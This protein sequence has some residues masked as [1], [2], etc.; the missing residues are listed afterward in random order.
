MPRAL[1]GGW[2]AAG[3]LAVVAGVA[4]TGH[5]SEDRSATES[6]WSAP[7][8]VT[9][10]QDGLAETIVLADPSGAVHLFFADGQSTRRQTTDLRYARW[11]DGHWS[12]P[13]TLV[14]PRGAAAFIHPALALDE[15]GRLHAVYGGRRSGRIEYR[16][17]HLSEVTD[18]KAWTGGRT[19]SERGGLHSAVATAPGGMVYVL[20]SSHSH[21]VSFH[22]SD[23]GGRTWSAPVRLSE[24][25]PSQQACDDP[26]LAVDG[27][28]RLHVVWTQFHLPQGWPPAGVYYRRSDDA[29]LT[30]QAARLVAGEGH[31]RITVATHGLDE[32]HLAW[33]VTATGERMH[34]WSDDGGATWSGARPISTRIRGAVSRALALA[35]DSGGILHL[36]AGVGGPG[37]GGPIVHTWW[38]GA[39]WSEPQPVSQDP[40]Q[41]SVGLPSLAISQ[42][43][44]LHVIYEDPDQRIW[45]ID[46][47][48]AAPPIDPRPLPTPARDLWTRFVDASLVFRA[49]VVLLAGL[50]IEA[51]VNW[52]L[53]RRR[54]AAP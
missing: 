35:F 4:A 9:T 29:G 37:S 30:W 20:Y 33:S 26:R 51:S 25:D 11:E 45:T 19:L 21:D 41:R 13:A 10:A 8:V 23:N 44:H 16:R 49:F 7:A 24:L 28:G 5:G 50:A 38:N 39:E 47:R 46:R 54:E 18:Q 42:G 27:R 14:A 32:V 15:R 3:A 12:E 6:S 17:V 31:G 34:E 52:W 1:T 48:V 43:N 40:A 2:C 36:V 22:R 53:R